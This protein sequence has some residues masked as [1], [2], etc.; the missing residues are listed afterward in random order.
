MIDRHVLSLF[1]RFLIFCF[2]TEQ[3]LFPPQAAK[4]FKIFNQ[5]TLCSLAFLKH[6]LSSMPSGTFRN[7]VVSYIYKIVVH[8][9]TMPYKVELPQIRNAP[10]H[11]LCCPRWSGKSIATLLPFQFRCNNGECAPVFHPTRS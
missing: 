5:V 10:A 6:A 4:T 9:L 7:L 2:S 3:K 1:C 8:S 11:V